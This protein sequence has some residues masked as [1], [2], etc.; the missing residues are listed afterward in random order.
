MRFARCAIRLCCY[1]NGLWVPESQRRSLIPTPAPMPMS[2]EKEDGKEGRFHFM[3]AH[4]F[5]LLTASVTACGGTVAVE[6]GLGDA[7]VSQSDAR[8]RADASPVDG[9]IGTSDA[10]LPPTNEAGCP[11]AYGEG[12]ASACPMNGT[13]DYAAGRCGCVPCVAGSAPSGYWDCRAWDSGIGA[14]CPSP[15]PLAGTACT[16]PDATAC[17]YGACCGDISLGTS[18]ECANGAWVQPG[19]CGSC[20]VAA[21]CP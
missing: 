19:P 18:V 15:P 13:C 9:A 4:V 12:R 1:A 10:M 7:G 5:V 11:L 3:Q 16:E 20:P 2:D 6:A 21:Q 8:V 17:Y 14:N